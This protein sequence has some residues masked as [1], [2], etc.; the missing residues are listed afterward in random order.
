MRKRNTR[1]ASRSHRPRH[2]HLVGKNLIRKNLGSQNSQKIQNTKS[3]FLNQTQPLNQKRSQTSTSWQA[4]QHNQLN[5]VKYLCQ[6]FFQHQAKHISSSRNN[7]SSN[8]SSLR[9]SRPNPS[10]LSTS[11][12]NLNKLQL[13]PPSSLIKSTKPK[14]CN[15]N[16]NFNPPQLKRSP[17]LI[18]SSQ[19]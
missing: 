1:S 12:S 2:H 13:N 9:H 10:Q 19:T 6:T 5:R 8:S 18:A 3:I 11:C 17:M 15:V 14:L 7:N 4:S 16:S